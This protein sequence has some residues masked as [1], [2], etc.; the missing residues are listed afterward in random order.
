MDGL[1]I[2]SVGSVIRFVVMFVIVVFLIKL[3]PENWKQ[4][5]RI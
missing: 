5:F 3:L 4:Y 1:K 2:P